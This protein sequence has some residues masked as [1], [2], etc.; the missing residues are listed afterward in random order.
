MK[1]TVV[2]QYFCY[3]RTGSNASYV[4]P[5]PASHLPAARRKKGPSGQVKPESLS[6]FCKEKGHPCKSNYTTEKEEKRK[7]MVVGEIDHNDYSHCDY[8]EDEHENLCMCSAYG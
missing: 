3:Y 6:H 1:L 2:Q 8:I 7:D 4:K 5:S